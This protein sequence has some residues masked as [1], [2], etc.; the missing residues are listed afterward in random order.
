MNEIFNFNYAIEC[1]KKK[2]RIVIEKLN[3]D[4]ENLSNNEVLFKLLT[5]FIQ[6]S[7]FNIDI[8]SIR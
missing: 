1:K 6:K 8:I 4:K 5:Q 3:D 7:L 2:K